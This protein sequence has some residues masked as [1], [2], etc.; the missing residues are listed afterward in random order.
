MN[1]HVI[2]GLFLTLVVFGLGVVGYVFVAQNVEE[3]VRAFLDAPEAYAPNSEL[4]YDAVTVFPI[5]NTVLVSGFKFSTPNQSLTADQVM[6]EGDGLFFILPSPSMWDVRLMDVVV[7]GK[8]ISENEDLSITVSQSRVNGVLTEEIEK[9]GLAGI[10]NAEDLEFTDLRF[11]K[12]DDAPII[13][14]DQVS[15]DSINDGAI[16]EIIL[17]GYRAKIDSASMDLYTGYTTPPASVFKGGALTVEETKLEDVNI[18]STFALYQRMAKGEEVS[19]EE[20]LAASQQFEVK[21]ISVTNFDLEIPDDHGKI[22]Y[23]S[24]R[25]TFQNYASGFPFDGSIKFRDLVVAPNKASVDSFNESGSLPFPIDLS[26]ATAD[27]IELE[28]VLDDAGNFELSYESEDSFSDMKIAFSAEASGMTAT[29]RAMSGSGPLPKDN[30]SPAV[31]KVRIFLNSLSEWE[32]PKT[33][34]GR[35]TARAS[36]L[37]DLTILSGAFDPQITEEYVAPITGFLERGGA[38]SITLDPDEPLTEQVL[39]GMLVTGGLTDGS[40]LPDLGL[41]VNLK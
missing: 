36:F 14:F 23:G 35:P 7:E 13:S 12:I 19:D 40:A 21:E 33:L 10:W 38:L 6:L 15:F 2:V 30:E 8:T 11:G 9:N 29:L 16:G 26:E 5:T 17:R 25:A 20:M 1:R 4:S 22:A 27:S 32:A 31:E 18:G 34:D 28:Y 24:L 41:S 39:F 37:S 3:R